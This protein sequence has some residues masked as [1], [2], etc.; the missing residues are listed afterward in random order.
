MSICESQRGSKIKWNTLK[1]SLEHVHAVLATV[2]AAVVVCVLLLCAM[3]YFSIVSISITMYNFAC[4]FLVCHT[5]S[6]G[7]LLWYHWNHD[8]KQ[9]QGNLTQVEAIQPIMPAR[10]PHQP[11]IQQRKCKKKN[12]FN[13][14]KKEKNCIFTLRHRRWMEVTVFTPFCLFVC[15]LRNLKIS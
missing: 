10:T 3:K 9:G 12:V 15:Y 1:G 5:S 13:C 11:M 8:I 4:S 6:S 14:W 7:F 2:L